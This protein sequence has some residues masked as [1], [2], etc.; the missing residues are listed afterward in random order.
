MA[1]LKCYG[2][3]FFLPFIHGLFIYYT[4]V[5]SHFC[6][7]P[8]SRALDLRHSTL[9]VIR[10]GWPDNGFII[11]CFY[12]YCLCVSLCLAFCQAAKTTIEVEVP[13]PCAS[14]KPSLLLLE[15]LI[16]RMLLHSPQEASIVYSDRSGFSILQSFRHFCP[17]RLIAVPTD[18]LATVKENKDNV[19]HVCTF[20]AVELLLQ[21]LL[22]SLLEFCS[23]LKCVGLSYFWFIA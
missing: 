14:I 22:S 20:K 1:E 3:G 7:R 15:F 2:E 18:P 11:A 19:V 12:N 21:L 5:N 16:K 13:L 17:L 10:D 9:T 8:F 4:I 23:W 6:I